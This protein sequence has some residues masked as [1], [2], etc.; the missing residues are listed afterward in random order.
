MVFLLIYGRGII[1]MN[2]F[3]VFNKIKDELVV[4]NHFAKDILEELYD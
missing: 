2:D 4:V 1:I 3:A